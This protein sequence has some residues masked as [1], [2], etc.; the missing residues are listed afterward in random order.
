MAVKDLDDLSVDDISVDHLSVDDLSV[1]L[2]YLVYVFFFFFR[3]S[4]PSFPHQ[5]L[6]LCGERSRHPVGVD[7][8]RVQPLRLKEG[9]VLCAVGESLHL[10]IRTERARHGN[11]RR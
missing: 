4:L 8:V 6:N 5:G 3:F 9:Q 11:Q 7:H 2:V 1:R 10:Y